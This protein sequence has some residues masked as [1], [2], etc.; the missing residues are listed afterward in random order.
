V[1]SR[2]TL[3][4]RQESSDSKIEKSCDPIN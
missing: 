2:E 1:Q 4:R 3:H